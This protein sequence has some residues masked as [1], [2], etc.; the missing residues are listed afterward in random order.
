MSADVISCSAAISACEKDGRWAMALKI[1]RSMYKLLHQDSWTGLCVEFCWR[2]T[3]CFQEEKSVLQNN[4]RYLRESELEF[5][6]LRTNSLRVEAAFFNHVF[7]W[8]PVRGFLVSEP[9]TGC[10]PR[11]VSLSN[12]ERSPQHED[13]ALCFL[14]RNC[15]PHPSPTRVAPTHCR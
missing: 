15:P 3:R 12:A 10:T 4:W 14:L 6:V 9:K 1:L 7:Q 2:K 5:H 8:R 11:V 13:M